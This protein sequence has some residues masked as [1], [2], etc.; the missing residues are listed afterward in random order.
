MALVVHPEK[1]VNLVCLVS[2][3][4]LDLQDLRVTKDLQDLLADRVTKANA[5]ISVFKEKEENRALE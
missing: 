4:T 1:K 2:L 5:E 3:D